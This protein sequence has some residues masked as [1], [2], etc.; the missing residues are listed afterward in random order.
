MPEVDR[1]A[2]A[3][4]LISEGR[5][6][7]A[8]EEFVRLSRTATARQSEIYLLEAASIFVDAGDLGRARSLAEAVSTRNAGPEIRF[9]RALAVSALELASGRP[10]EAL[11]ELPP[12]L[13]AGVPRDILGRGHYLR[14]RASEGLGL[15]L[16][17]ARSRV[18]AEPSII[19]PVQRARNRDAIWNNL[20]QVPAQML[21]QSLAELA[22]PG[23]YGGWLSLELLWQRSIGDPAAL[24]AGLQSWALQYPGHP[25][26]LELVPR[27]REASEQLVSVPKKIALLLPFEGPF[28]FAAPRYQG[29]LRCRLVRGCWAS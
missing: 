21:Q 3:R 27:L 16:Q 23:P 12:E 2:T 7:E 29:R 1:S 8:G 6:A 11:K 25:A 24:A 4:A 15:A 14:A 28:E 22:V 26:A 13:Q 19:S 5:L 20:R 10:E 18:L 9:R 17:A